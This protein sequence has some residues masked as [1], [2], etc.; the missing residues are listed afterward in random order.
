M[1]YKRMVA[2]AL[3]CMFIVSILCIPA[4]AASGTFYKPE[5][6]ANSSKNIV[7]FYLSY[8]GCCGGTVTANPMSKPIKFVVYRGSTTYDILPYWALL[9]SYSCANM[10][11]GYT[12]TLALKAEAHTAMGIEG[13]YY[14]Y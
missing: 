11:A 4:A 3:V 8:E 2:L 6:P 13:T 5:I 10:K 7:S 9:P 14:Y 12:Y 1:K